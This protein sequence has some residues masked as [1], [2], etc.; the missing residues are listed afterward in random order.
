MGQKATVI[1]VSMGVAC[2]IMVVIVVGANASI[3][4]L[5]QCS[6]SELLL[7][8]LVNSFTAGCLAHVGQV[9]V[10]LQLLEWQA[11]K[12]NLVKEWVITVL[13]DGKWGEDARRMG[14]RQSSG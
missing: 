1:L 7:C 2:F 14:M 8:F 5:S 13:V 6:G 4:E 11:I 10:V 9:I 12:E 3:G